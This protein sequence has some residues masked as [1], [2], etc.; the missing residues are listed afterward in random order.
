MSMNIKHLAREQL[1][2]YHFRRTNYFLNASCFFESKLRRMR[3][4]ITSSVLATSLSVK[5]DDISNIE[6]RTFVTY[7][8]MFNQSNEHILF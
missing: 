5:S 1:L 7:A 3:F 6:S 2:P 8:S 4:K